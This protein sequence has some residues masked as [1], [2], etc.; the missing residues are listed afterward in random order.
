MARTPG[1]KDRLPRGRAKVD[2]GVIPPTV[3]QTRVYTDEDREEAITE[4]AK[5]GGSPVKASRTTGV[6]ARTLRRWWHELTDQER[7]DYLRIARERQEAWWQ[8]VHD[9]ALVVTKGKIKDL[10]PKDAAIVAGIAFDKLQLM[11]GQST[12]ITGT[13][14]ADAASLAKSVEDILGN[15]SVEENRTAA[16]TKPKPPEE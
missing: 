7:D 2:P 4:V 14:A 11:R 16:R 10:A 3:S 5:Q 1:S 8:D 6:P 9:A 13:L 15:I 12:S